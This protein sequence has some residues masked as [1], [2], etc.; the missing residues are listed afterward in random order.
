M[1][2]KLIW[3]IYI[4]L[5]YYFEFRLW[6][7]VTNFFDIKIIVN[8][9]AIRIW[10]K[11]NSPKLKSNCRAGQNKFNLERSWNF[12]YE[13]ALKFQIFL[14]LSFWTVHMFA[15]LSILEK[16]WV[17]K[18]IDNKEF[19][20]F[21]TVNVSA[22]DSEKTSSKYMGSRILNPRPDLKWSL[23]SPIMIKANQHMF[24]NKNLVKIDYLCENL[25]Y[26]SPK[27]VI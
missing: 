15:T 3:N 25:D 1:A 22:S 18:S 5:L 14:Y 11:E 9:L 2:V 26:K 6:L 10:W 19:F 7:S 27:I 4:F 16:D 17:C 20:L 12:S 21:T 23:N 24:P 13:L 8:Y